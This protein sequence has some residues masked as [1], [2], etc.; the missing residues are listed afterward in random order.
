MIDSEFVDRHS[1]FIDVGCYLYLASPYESY[2]NKDN[3]VWLSLVQLSQ[4]IMLEKN[5]FR[6]N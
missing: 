4:F 2:E 6:N 5:C 3:P 1:R